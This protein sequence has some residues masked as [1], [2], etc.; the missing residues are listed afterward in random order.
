MGLSWLG[1]GDT[2][3]RPASASAGGAVTAG[4]PRAVVLG[5]LKSRTS[6]GHMPL[7]TRQAVW[8]V[9]SG[10]RDAVPGAPAKGVEPAVN[11]SAPTSC[12][13]FAGI[14]D[15]LLGIGRA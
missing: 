14:A 12:A 4:G 9:T 7:G 2:D 15:G 6:E 13:F 3:L 10:R 8:R 5:N 1:F 11:R